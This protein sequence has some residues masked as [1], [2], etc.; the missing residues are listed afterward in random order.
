MHMI[1]RV[2]GKRYKVIEKIGKGGMADVYKAEDSVL[3]RVLAIKVLHPQF[4]QENNFVAR[5]KTE[6]QAAAGLNHP[7]I[8]S[9]YDWGHEDDTYFIAMEYL[10]GWNLKQLI[11]A[12]APLPVD[13]ALEMAAQVCSALDFAHQRGIIHRDIKSQNIIIAP[14]G[15][16]KVADFG[17]ARAGGASMTQTGS[18]MGTAEYISP[19][20]AQGIEVGRSGDIYSLGIVLYEALTGQLPFKGESPLAVAMKQVREKPLSPSLLNSEISPP[21]EQVILRSLEKNPADRYR[22]AEE[23]KQDLISISKGLP[24][25]QPPPPV[26][27]DLGQTR[28]M[29]VTNAAPPRRRPPAKSNAKPLPPMLKIAGL[30]LI[31][32]LGAILIFNAFIGFKVVVPD[33]ID[34]SLKEAK[35]ELEDAGLKVAD[36]DGF[37]KEDLGSPVLEQDPEAGTKARRG[38]AV[39]LTLEGSVEVPD[40]VGLPLAEA[41]QRLG[42][43]GLGFGVEEKEDEE[44]EAGTVISQLPEAGKRMAPGSTVDL[45][46]SAGGPKIMPNLLGQ[47]EAEALGLLGQLGIAQ[48]RITLKEVASSEGL[49]TIVGQSPEPNKEIP[50]EAKIILEISKGPISIQMPKLT[51]MTEQ[52]A[53]DKL[54]KLGFNPDDV[55]LDKAEN[56]IEGGTNYVLDQDPVAFERVEVGMVIILTVGQEG[57]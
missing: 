55:N 14:H 38:S 12:Q 29:P 44:A 36:F 40:V 25:K 37:A 56:Y 15:Q 43:A 48:E 24:I 49:G 21:L 17:I 51:G 5:F 47:T 8:V 16:V 2:F 30:G 39:R 46:V 3:N 45:I 54:K 23:M 33:V 50:V 1:G 52:A 10:E 20:Q 35:A 32:I 28:V 6:A 22:S 19:E 9:I 31:S 53:L 7:N 26:E 18:V 57:G 4:A 41:T 42:R 27:D 34:M 13:E 11:E